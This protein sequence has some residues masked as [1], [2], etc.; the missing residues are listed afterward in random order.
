MMKISMEVQMLVDL[1]CGEAD[2]SMMN[3][4]NDG[5]SDDKVVVFLIVTVSC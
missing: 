4:W 1:Q 3:C 5:V 2:G